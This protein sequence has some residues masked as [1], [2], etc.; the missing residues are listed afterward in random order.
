MLPSRLAAA[1]SL[2]CWVGNVLVR[3]QCVLP[4]QPELP[5]GRVGEQWNKGN[6]ECLLSKRGVIWEAGKTRGKRFGRRLRPGP[7][8]YLAEA[9]NAFKERS[10]GVAPTE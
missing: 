9:R 2:G 5:V 1:P 10:T 3:G 4:G 8:G 6:A 7:A